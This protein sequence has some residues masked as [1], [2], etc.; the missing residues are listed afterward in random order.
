MNLL[1]PDLVVVLVKYRNRFR[2][3]RGERELWVLDYRKWAKDFSD[4][5]YD[6][7]S[8]ADERGRS[9]VVAARAPRRAA[10][11]VSDRRGTCR[12]ASIL[13]GAAST[14]RRAVSSARPN[15]SGRELK[16]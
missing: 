4:A 3:F 6:V 14:A 11:V 2:W 15:E 16:P 5:G 12:V 9:K 8:S 13:S 7:D 10:L 1:E